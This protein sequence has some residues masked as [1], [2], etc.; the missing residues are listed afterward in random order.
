M[1]IK[2]PPSETGLEKAI[3]GVLSEMQG[4][5]ASD[6][7]YSDMVDQL[8]K[9]HSLKLKEKRQRVSPDIL[10]TVAANLVG[11]LIIVGHERTHIV[12]SKALSFVLKL[13]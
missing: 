1:F 9:L 4:Y 6:E 12:T 2:K 8:V 10:V 11:I 3:D 13:R 7:E 5:S